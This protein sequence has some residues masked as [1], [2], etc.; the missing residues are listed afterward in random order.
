MGNEDAA[1]GRCHNHLRARAKRLQALSQ[2]RPN[3]TG[4]RR[5]LK[6]PRTLHVLGT[7]QPGTQQEVTLQQRAGFL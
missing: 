2:S 4:H 6:Q 3:L 1:N 7:M 5:K